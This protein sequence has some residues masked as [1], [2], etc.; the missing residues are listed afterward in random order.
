[1]TNTLLVPIYLD[2]LYLPRETNVLGEMTDYT[3]LPYYK[4]DTKLENRTRTFLSE[5][6]LST[7]LEKP[8]LLLKAGIHLH[9]T[10]P[11]ALTNGIV[12]EN[13]E[14]RRITFPLVPN[15]WLIIRR[16][17]NQQEKTWVVESNYLHPES[18]ISEDTRKT[19]INIYYPLK[20]NQYQPYRL[21][22]RKLTLQDWKKPRGSRD[23]YI[24][25]LSAIGPF[26][27]VDSLDNEKAAFAG[28]YP[29]CSSVFGFHD[30]EIT[31]ATP[32]TDL[33]YDVIGWYS[34][35]TK[36]YLSKFIPEHS[37]ERLS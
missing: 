26:A 19:T 10:L 29:N 2:A 5:T 34:D 23:E 24:P 7:P 31:T 21:L 32:P 27:K 20:K 11:D 36:D 16:G 17:G 14:D 25:E 9:W 12:K 28:F 8:T 35:G 4:K 1:M 13:E 33:Q 37:E 3:K 22:G 15:R 30:E 18:L 6:V